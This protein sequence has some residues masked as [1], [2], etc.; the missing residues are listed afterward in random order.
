[1]WNTL[2]QHPARNLTLLLLVGS[3]GINIW[4]VNVIKTGRAGPRR[5]HVGIGAHLPPVELTDLSGRRVTLEFTTTALPTIVYWYS[6]D[7][8]WCRRNAANIKALARA[9]EGRYRFIGISKSDRG[10]REYLAASEY[11]F[12]TYIDPTGH[13]R[14]AY[15]LG[16]TPMTLLISHEGT[17]SHIWNGAYDGKRA[18]ELETLFGFHLPGI[19]AAGNSATVCD[20][21]VVPGNA[22]AGVTR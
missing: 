1:M 8:V 12:P 2:A 17:L 13:A 14:D 16:G 19:D 18:T 20:G 11:S 7:C 22:V 10:L 4:L 5:P 9:A 21:C 15:G 3:I 6:P